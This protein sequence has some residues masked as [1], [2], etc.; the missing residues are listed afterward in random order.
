MGEALI[1]AGL[2]IF[3]LRD[4][5]HAA[6]VTRLK[7]G[8]YFFDPYLLHTELLN[9]S[10]LNENN[11]IISS[12]AYPFR[13]DKDGNERK[14]KLEVRWLGDDKIRVVYWIFSTQR[15][16]YK[17][18]RLFNFNLKDKYPSNTELNFK[19]HVALCFDPEQTT[20]SIRSVNLEHQ[21]MW[22]LVYPIWKF[23]NKKEHKPENLFLV[24]N[25]GQVCNAIDP[26]NN[27]LYL[28]Q[29]ADSINSTETKLLNF[30]MEGVSIYENHAPANI[31][32]LV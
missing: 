1:N 4:H 26:D 30:M 28:N 27:N 5:R 23:H 20:L 21:E 2:D 6:V 8:D 3:Y 11:R 14:S 25:Q 24:D 9:L 10:E 17:I 12:E 19:N 29:F 18:N 16:T 22:Q 32:Y 31:K 7:D 15:N 13:K